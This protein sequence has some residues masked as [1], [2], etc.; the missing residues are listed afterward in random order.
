M[1]Y[2]RFL[3]AIFLFLLRYHSEAQN[4]SIS[5]T[6][7]DSS[8]KQTL[9]LAT[10][11]IYKAKDTSIISYRLSDENGNFK[12]PN[13]PLNV[14]C[15]ILISFSGYF[16]FRREF[17]LTKEKTDEKLGIISLVPNH[18]QLEQIFI[19]AE[20]P[21]VIIKKDT[22]EFNAFAFKT[23]PNA[24]VEDL[25]KKLPG[26]D[27]DRDGNITVNGKT[28]NR[29]LVDGRNFF[30]GDPKMA[31]RNLPANIID[32]IQVTDDNEQLQRNPDIPKAELGQVINLKLKKSI[33]QGWFGKTYAGEGTNEKY[34]AGGILN[35]FKDTLQVSIL[36]YS[37]NLNKS[38]FG[39]NDLR[40]LGGFNR[41]GANTSNINSEGGLSINGISFGGTGRGIQTSTGAGMNLNND[42]KNVNFN[43][44]Y[45]YGKINNQLNQSINTKQFSRDT[46]LNINSII[47]EKGNDINN[48]IS[49]VIK[50]KPS[51]STTL[52]FKPTIIF[53]NND[54]VRNIQTI[55]SNNFQGILNTSNNQQHFLGDD[56]SFSQE[57]SLYHVFKKTGR[58]L[59]AYHT[60]S[61][62]NND[63][64][65]YNDV[66]STFYF[67]NIRVDSNLN[68]L[69]KDNYNNFRT[70]IFGTY[71]DPLSK[72]VVLRLTE[73]LEYSKETDDLNSFS[74]DSVKNEYNI[75]NL[76]LSDELER[77]RWKNSTSIGIKWTYKKFSFSPGLN[78]LLFNINNSYLKTPSILQNYSYLFPSLNITWKKWNFS[79]RISVREPS[80]S[81]LKTIIDNTN[82]LYKQL[83]NPNLKPI[84]SNDI[85]LDFNSFNIKRI[86]SYALSFGANLEHNSIIRERIIDNK[87]IQYIIPININGVWKT[88]VSLN[89][90]KQIKFNRNCQLSLRGSIS[91]D[92]N[93]SI[94][95]VNNNFS[96]QYYFA[97]YP[98][99]SSSF[100][101]KDVFEFNEIYSLTWSKSSYS[102][103]V[104]TGLTTTFHYLSS[105]I[106]VHY[107]NKWV[108]ESSVDYS[109]NPIVFS[110]F[111]KSNIRWNAGI[112]HLFLKEN[113]GLIKIFVYDILNQN[114]STFRIVRENFIQDTQTNVLKRYFLA[115]FT[116]NI[117]NFKPSKIGG[118]DKLFLF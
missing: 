111:R 114:I 14:T 51:S 56:L 108:W 117:R 34:E 20:R 80:Y 118:R 22:I 30:G 85:S 83:G 94:V 99:I 6:L 61:N 84:V 101:F 62:S 13:I 42:F 43:L 41:S 45:F 67:N 64:N 60:V 75:P 29:I 52:G 66:A 54:N 96:D 38:G 107:P 76:L 79:Y 50:W 4:G 7:K 28:V 12:V 105:D 48:R 26:V 78:F 115:T 98:R 100:N 88:F 39:Y 33:K 23:L 103:P 104:F 47:D 11:T 77:V 19:E 116:Y 27:V 71:T 16:I 112:T 31:T 63:F 97:L 21:P 106:A 17:L 87:G 102:N 40:S 44:Q 49:S 3:F 65:Q 55:S 81:D 8:T 91:D 32:K 86:E 72:K 90:T 15:R 69:R 36:G 58:S 82:P 10:V 5:G 95:I 57:I 110:G 92:Y 18:T 89:M 59:S 2:L 53:H 73:S 113:K 35:L 24:L 74:K 25:L 70:N 46:I 93:K 9:S 109:Y 1:Q 68:Q 37:N